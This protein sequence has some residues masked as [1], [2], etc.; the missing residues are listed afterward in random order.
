MY[1]YNSVNLYKYN[2]YIKLKFKYHTDENVSVLLFFLLGK[3]LAATD[4]KTA[5]MLLH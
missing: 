1:L 5:M 2:I 3:K 4:S